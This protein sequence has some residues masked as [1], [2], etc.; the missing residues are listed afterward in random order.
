MA[1]VAER[2]LIGGPAVGDLQLAKVDSA[3]LAKR[4]AEKILGHACGDH[5]NLPVPPEPREKHL[6]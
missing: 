5:V 4:V 6:H 3:E 2:R 1:L